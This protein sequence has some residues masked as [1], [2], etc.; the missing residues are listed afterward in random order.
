MILNIFKK[1][2][3]KSKQKKIIITIIENLNIKSN[4]KK[5]YL[6]SIDFLN[7]DWLNKLYNSLQSYMWNIELKNIDDIKKQSFTTIAW[8][9]KKEV[10]E[11]QKEINNFWFLLNNL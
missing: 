7:E 10:L 1:Y 4:Q 11:K 6:D 2:R 8:M 5:L 9:R 3:E